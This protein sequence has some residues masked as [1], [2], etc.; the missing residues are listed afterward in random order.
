M[1]SPHPGFKNTPEPPHRAMGGSPLPRG[2]CGQ[3]LPM[4]CAPCLSQGLFIQEEEGVGSG[5][6]CGGRGG[7][8]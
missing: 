6:I 5:S 8:I 4:S 2:S 7:L 1:M 3:P